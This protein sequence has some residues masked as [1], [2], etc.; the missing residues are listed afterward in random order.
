MDLVVP[1]AEGWIRQGEWA[2]ATLRG[3]EP[4]YWIQI[5]PA[6]VATARLLTRVGTLLGK[7]TLDLGCGLGVPGIAAARA[8]AAVTFADRQPEALAFAGWN[9][10]RQP[11]AAAASLHQIDW[12]REVVPGTFDLLLLSDVSYR[13]LHHHALKRHVAAVLDA[14]GVVLHADPLRRE[15]TPFVNWLATEFATVCT[16]RRTH[17][18]E[19]TLEVRLCVATR[20]PAALAPWQR[21]SGP[22]AARSDTDPASSS[23]EPTNS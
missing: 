8:G 15:A 14:D 19:R 7:R 4:P 22:L 17:F 20:S 21:A 9:A 10:A 16:Q 13:P 2:D 18:L 23:S 12:S 3:A 6:A 5:W 1:D 11:S